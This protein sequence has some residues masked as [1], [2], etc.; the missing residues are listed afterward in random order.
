MILPTL[1]YTP[2][3]QKSSLHLLQ[4]SSVVVYM[5]SLDPLKTEL[6]S[7]YWTIWIK[8]FQRGYI[9]VF[10]IKHNVRN[11]YDIL[12]VFHTLCVAV[13]GPGL[14]GRCW[15]LRGCSTLHPCE[16]EGGLAKGDPPWPDGWQVAR[17]CRYKSCYPLLGRFPSYSW[18]RKEPITGCWG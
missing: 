12:N 3:P 7:V 10:D 9:M 2:P 1:P 6:F 4:K 16:T 15:R 5:M 11:P 17:D 14:P 8:H 13:W 18:E